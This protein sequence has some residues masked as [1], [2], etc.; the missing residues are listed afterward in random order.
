MTL[1]CSRRVTQGTVK[2]SLFLFVAFMKGL[3]FRDFVAQCGTGL[4]RLSLA[5]CFVQ[6]LALKEKGREMYTL[7]SRRVFT[8][9]M[10]LRV[11]CQLPYENM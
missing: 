8:S 9:N 1:N 11:V 4:F 5:K 3:S 7:P 6:L 10:A 2:K